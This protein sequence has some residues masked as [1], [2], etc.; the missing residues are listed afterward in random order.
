MSAN[1]FE[2]L[3]SDH[4]RQR[5][6]VARLLETTGDSDDRDSIFREL[7]LEMTA[8]AD[9]EERNLYAPM[10][11]HDLSQ[12]KARHSVAEHKELDDFL[13]ELDEIERSSP[14]W[15]VVA[16][17]MEHRLTHHLDEE[18]H[19]MFQIAGRVLTDA[20]KVELA[21]AYTAGMADRRAG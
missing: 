2:A 3:R 1:I 18:E 19:E 21:G 14:R 11:D 4:D 7:R 9:M 6:L 8:H 10:M 17:D 20:A 16:K 13:E 12:E 5:E 15:L